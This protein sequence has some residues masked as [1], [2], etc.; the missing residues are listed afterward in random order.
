[1]LLR[2]L[3][4]RR[5][6]PLLVKDGN[7]TCPCEAGSRDNLAVMMG[8]DFVMLALVE[9]DRLGS[10]GM[11]DMA[12]G[13]TAFLDVEGGTTTSSSS[14][15]NGN[16]GISSASTLPRTYPLGKISRDDRYSTSQS[17]PGLKEDLGLIRS[18]LA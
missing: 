6:I 11:D 3:T 5:C 4:V 16:G 2:F 18:S 15:T 1:M 10:F 9:S 13:C 17:A 12:A 8:S 14:N 7:L